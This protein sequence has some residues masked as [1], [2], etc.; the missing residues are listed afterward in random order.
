MK[1]DKT[2]LIMAA[3][4]GSRFGGLKQIE[5]VGPNGEFIIDYSI[6]DAIEAGFTKVVFIVKEDFYEKFKETIGKRIE[7]YIKVEY[8]FQND[9]YIPTRF[10]ALLKKRIKPLGT[11]YAIL[12]AKDKINEPFAVINAD[13]YYGKDA[14]LKASKYLDDIIYNHYGIVGYKVG[15]TLS[16]NGTSKRGIMEVE[17]NKLLR[18]TESKVAPKRNKIIAAP[19]YSSNGKEIDEDTLVCMNLLLFSPDIFDILS[20]EL[21]L[22]LSLHQKNLD[23]YE[24]QIPDVLDTCLRKNIKTIDVINTTSTWYGMTYK[25]DKETVVKALRKLTDEGLYPQHLWINN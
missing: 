6:Y 15:N 8:A 25:E 9:D 19:L 17:D 1:K 5:K 23:D 20:D 12:C 22:F 21:Y 2:L 7:P 10:K 3:G 18:I 13:D 11:A 16:P 4:L 14:F 24:F